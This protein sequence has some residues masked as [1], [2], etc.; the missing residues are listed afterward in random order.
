MIDAIFDRIRQAAGTISVLDGDL[1][2]RVP[3]GLLSPADRAVL[4]EHRDEIVRLLADET[5]VEEHL[6]QHADEVLDQDEEPIPCSICG[7][8][9]AWWDTTGRRHCMICQAER[10][11][12]SERLVDRAA[13]VRVKSRLLLSTPLIRYND[14]SRQGVVIPSRLLTTTQT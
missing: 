7:S 10:L 5:V 2:L 11:E 8:L 4:V 9:M 1:R 14:R 3:K 13:R 12:R 6:D